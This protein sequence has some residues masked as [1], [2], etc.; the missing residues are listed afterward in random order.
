MAVGDV[1]VSTKNIQTIVTEGLT[2]TLEA[3]GI[4]RGMAGV[5]EVVDVVQGVVSVLF[6]NGIRGN[7]GPTLVDKLDSIGLPLWPT[8]DSLAVQSVELEPRQQ[9]VIGKKHSVVSYDH[10]IQAERI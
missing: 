2:T 7:F 4:P 1:V 10:L 8:E 3:N 9:L 5:V 6:D